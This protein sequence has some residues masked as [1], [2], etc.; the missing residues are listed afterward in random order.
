[1]PCIALWEPS[2]SQGR[3]VMIVALLLTVAMLFHRRF[4]NY[5]LLPSCLALTGGI[6]AVS[7]NFHAL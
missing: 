7:V 2:F 6:A 1:M 3:L 5:L 4:R